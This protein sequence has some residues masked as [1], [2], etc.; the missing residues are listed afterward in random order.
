[1]TGT[2]GFLSNMLLLFVTGAVFG[3]LLNSSGCNDRIGR[4]LTRIFGEKNVIYIVMVFAMVIAATGASPILIVAYLACGLMKGA[5]L[6]RYVGMCAMSG[7]MIMTQ[8]VL[9]I[10]GTIGNLIPTFYLP[11]TI[12]AAPLMGIIAFL[13]GMP[14]NIIYVNWLVRDARAKGRGYDPMKGEEKM[15][16]RNE[17][18]IPSFGIAILPV[19]SIIAFCFIAVL[20]FHINS[21]QA[22]V[23]AAVFGSILILITCRKYIH[24]NKLEL[25]NDT[26][27]PLLPAIIGTPIVVGFAS[28]VANTA[29][30]G[31]AIEWITALKVNPYVLVLVGTTL[32]CILCADCL[33][34]SSAFLALLGEKILGM[35]ANAEAV[36]RLTSITSTA[37]DSM[38]HNGSMIMIL[39]CYGYS[40]KEGYKYMLISNI[41][42]PMVMS[43]VAMIVAMVAY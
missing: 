33:A 31:T 26:V 43:I 23:Y 2:M 13:V 11:T 42:I 27:T 16:L 24:V 6:P 35:G 7:T 37:F 30:Y 29:I 4:T 34:G 12:Y 41:A 38:P 20:G 18:D 3:G 25:L 9:P 36:H 40:H 14:L 28:V 10:S 19:L 39:L 32:L 8:N 1:M 15:T 21:S 22:V 17:D 5:K